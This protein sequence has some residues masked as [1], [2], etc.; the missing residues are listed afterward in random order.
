MQREG[1]R[2]SHMEFVKL[3]PT[4]RQKVFNLPVPCCCSPTLELKALSVLDKFLDTDSPFSNFSQS[5]ALSPTHRLN[6]SVLTLSY[7]KASFK[8]TYLYNEKLA[9]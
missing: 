7:C 8:L 1:S 3:F 6:Y 2:A 4:V 5:K 9:L